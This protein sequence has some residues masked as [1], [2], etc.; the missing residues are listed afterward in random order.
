MAKAK[1]GG[2]R[3]ACSRPAF[4]YWNG[5]WVC[6]ECHRLEL[7]YYGQLRRVQRTEEINS[8]QNPERPATLETL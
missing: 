1:L 3:C 8:S 2:R 4:R 6:Q 7:L 5:D